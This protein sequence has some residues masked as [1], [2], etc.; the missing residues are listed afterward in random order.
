MSGPQV[1][2]DEPQQSAPQSSPQIKWDDDESAAVANRPGMPAFNPPMHKAFMIGEGDPEDSSHT[3]EGK[4]GGLAKTAYQVSIPGVATSL[5]QKKAPEVAAMLPGVMTKNAAPADELPGKIIGNEAPMMIGEDVP[6]ATRAEESSP[7]AVVPRSATSAEPPG[8]IGRLAKVGIDRI[9]GVKLTR[10][11]V[12]A[13]KGPEPPPMAPPPPAPIPETNGMRWGTGGKAPISEWGKPPQAVFPGGHLPDDPGTFP[14]ASLPEKPSSELVQA[15]PIGRGA[16]RPP[17]PAAGLGKLKAPKPEP[18][19]AKPNTSSNA[20][21]AQINDSL[22]GRPLQPGVKLRDQG[23]IQPPANAVLSDLKPVDSTAVKAY[24]YDPKAQEFTAT[25]ASG[26]TFVHGDV[27]PAE[28][29]VFEKAT[30][31]GKAWNEIRNNHPLV[32]KIVNGQ[33]INHVP[34]IRSASPNY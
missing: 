21:Q 24:K 5:L 3:L 27:S 8:M 30:S 28:A 10:D 18:A 17:E 31:K 23:K 7:R 29:K 16:I 25:S 34:S 9:P 20:I 19:I 13:I 14:G 1:S 12:G 4:I 32:A 11:V 2:W 6:P 33:R 15:R 22:G 26:Q